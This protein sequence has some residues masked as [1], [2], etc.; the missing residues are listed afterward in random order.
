MDP[1]HHK[2]YRTNIVLTRLT[3]YLY[4]HYI[5]ETQNTKL[6]L[7][8]FSKLLENHEVIMLVCLPP[9]SW[10]ESHKKDQK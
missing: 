2:E 7:S 5:L 1:K 8:L 3:F 9:C 4:A 10:L 6:L